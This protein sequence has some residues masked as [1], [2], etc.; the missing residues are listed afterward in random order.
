M[1]TVCAALLY[2]TT[3]LASLVPAGWLAWLAGGP[4]PVRTNV[5]RKNVR[6]EA[7]ILFF[8]VK[9][10]QQQTRRETKLARFYK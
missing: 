9:I 5:E 6:M 4:S 1:T 8:I 2:K 7:V 3:V 10:L